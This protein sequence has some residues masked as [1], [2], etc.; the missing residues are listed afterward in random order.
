[1][2][3]QADDLEAGTYASYRHSRRGSPRRG[4]D[5]AKFWETVA[6]IERAIVWFFATLTA[7]IW[8]TW[9]L[10][11]ESAQ[12]LRFFSPERIQVQF[13]YYRKWS[14]FVV[15]AWTLVL[16]VLV[17]WKYVTGGVSQ[18]LTYFTN[19]SLNIQVIYYTFDLVSYFTDPARRELEKWLLLVFWAPVFAQAFDVFVMVIFVYLD[20]ATIVT[21]NLESAGG[22]YDDGL[23][24]FIERVVH[25]FPLFIGMVYYVLRLHD[26][27]DFQVS[28]YGLIATMPPGSAPGKDQCIHERTFLAMRW[29]HS[30]RYILYQY[31]VAAIPFLIYVLVENV[32]TVYGINVFT[33]WM[34]VMAVFVLNVVCVVF[35]LYSIMFYFTPSR[36]VPASLVDYHKYDPEAT[37]LQM[38]D[39]TG[40]PSITDESNSYKWLHSVV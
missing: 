33:N 29:V 15:L 28:V 4:D 1:M 24:L 26:I 23:V 2:G 38:A 17:I 14:F 8:G 34:A 40:P 20:N 32:R 25:V 6:R 5:A 30:V 36:R 18:V 3:D 7:P 11:R 13:T 35:P 39:I 22:M 21:E 10:L 31:L 16:W 9:L 37:D 27:S 19:V 12:K